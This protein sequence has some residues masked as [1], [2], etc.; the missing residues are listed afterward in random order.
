LSYR[1]IS[2]FNEQ[3]TNNLAAH[4]HGRG[5]Y[6]KSFAA[7]KRRMRGLWACRASPN[8]P[9]RFTAGSQPSPG[10]QL[11]RSG[12]LGQDATAKPGEDEGGVNGR[13]RESFKPGRKWPGSFL[14][15]DKPA[16]NLRSSRPPGGWQGSWS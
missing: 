10:L 7:R 14:V 11:Q 12:R 6:Q 13:P 5:Q 2:L 1:G 15:T 16:C 8:L 4:Q 9:N 3:L